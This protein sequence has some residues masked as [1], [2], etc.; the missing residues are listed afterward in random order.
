MA[1]GN[2][3]VFIIVQWWFLLFNFEKISVNHPH[4]P[5]QMRE[6]MTKSLQWFPL[7]GRDSRIS[8]L[9]YALFWKE[10]ADV[11]WKKLQKVH[12]LRWDLRE[13]LA[14]A[15]LGKNRGYFYN[16]GTKTLTA[17]ELVVKEPKLHHS[18]L[19]PFLVTIAFLATKPSARAT[20]WSLSLQK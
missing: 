15:N 4:K 9:S 8:V 18:M 5:A 3:S 14:Q 1:W 12:W 6:G 10:T 7:L 17:T 11:C 13:N 19:R 2:W 16:P 20:A